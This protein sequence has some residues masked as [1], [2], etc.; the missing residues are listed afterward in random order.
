MLRWANCQR[1]PNN[2]T[3]KLYMVPI[4]H[5]FAFVEARASPMSVLYLL[6]SVNQ[7]DKAI[8]ERTIENG[9]RAKGKAYV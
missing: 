5:N 1:I 7:L 2:A 3:L 4:L 8:G 6:A 9:T